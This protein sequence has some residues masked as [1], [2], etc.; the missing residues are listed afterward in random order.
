[1]SKH[2]KHIGLQSRNGH[3]PSHA[4]VRT[5][6]LLLDAEQANS[7]HRTSTFHGFLASAKV[8]QAGLSRQQLAKLVRDGYLVGVIA[9]DQRSPDTRHSDPA[10][11]SDDTYLALTPSGRALGRYLLDS[12]SKCSI[13]QQCSAGLCDPA[14]T[15]A[16]PVCASVGE[17][18]PYWDRRSTDSGGAPS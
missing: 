18:V 8:R 17:F 11:D 12:C 13:S 3:T 4:L 6:G 5:I 1:M 15:S 16:T 14:V 9:A 2:N 7:S 10:A